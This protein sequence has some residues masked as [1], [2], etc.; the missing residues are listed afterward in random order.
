MTTNTGLYFKRSL[1]ILKVFL[2]K[3]LIF[4]EHRMIY[5]VLNAVLALANSSFSWNMINACLK[6]EFLEF[7]LK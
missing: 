3:L 6:V 5:N 1:H 4:E 2:G 7:L